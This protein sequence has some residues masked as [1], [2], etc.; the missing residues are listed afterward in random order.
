L[1]AR[2]NSDETNGSAAS[3]TCGISTFY[4]V[5]R[6][7]LDWPGPAVVSINGV[8]TSIAVTEFMVLVTGIREPVAHLRYRGDLT[9]LTKSLDPPHAGC[10]YC[11]ELWGRDS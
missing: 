7:A 11:S 4:G 8:V 2:G 5:D 1:R 9:Q 6:T 3:R 10:W